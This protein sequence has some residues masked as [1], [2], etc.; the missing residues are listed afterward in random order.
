MARLSEAKLVIQTLGIK[1][2]GRRV[3]EQ[4]GEDDVFTWAASL[5]Y[6]WIFA[7]FPFLIFLLTLVPLMPANARA[8]VGMDIHSSLKMLS[9]NAA[10]PIEDQVR[11]L[12]NQPRSGLLSIGLLVTIWAASGGMSMTMQALDR[13]YDIKKGRP[14]L[15]HRLVAILLTIVGAMLV[16]VVMVLMPIASGIIGWLDTHGR[17]LGP[18]LLLL[19]LFRFG[20]AILL[21]LAL[22]ALVYQW[23]LSIRTKF[24]FI[25]PG[26]VFSVAVWLILAFAFKLYIDAFGAASY[27]KT[28]GT[29]AGVAILL[30]FFYIDASVLLIGAEINS[31]VDFAMLGLP[32]FDDVQVHQFEQHHTEEH[33]QLLRELKEKREPV[34]AASSPV[35]APQNP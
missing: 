12:L 4:I 30:L 9:K 14:Y 27:N 7:L 29:V 34:T 32:S 10:A 21:M 28:Y 33:Q 6:S 5:A 16:I 18:V 20:F 26:A 23:G 2:F 22:L 3:W 13:C 11:D 31:E 1:E 8:E 35:P 15:K 19:N 25:T 17:I 24:H